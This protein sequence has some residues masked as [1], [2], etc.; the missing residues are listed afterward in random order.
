MPYPDEP[1]IAPGY[2]RGDWEGG[3]R[4]GVTESHI[5]NPCV[6]VRRPVSGQMALKQSVALWPPKPRELFRHARTLACRAW[7]G[8]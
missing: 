6:P 4:L 3:L 1:V 7:L 2:N 5:L 8:T